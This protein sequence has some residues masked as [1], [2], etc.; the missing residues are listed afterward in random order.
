MTN[1][2]HISDFSPGIE[3]RE[4]RGEPADRDA[5]LFFFFASGAGGYFHGMSE[6]ID[7]EVTLGLTTFKRR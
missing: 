3:K 6:W 5:F 7:L 1:Y 4:N 2:F